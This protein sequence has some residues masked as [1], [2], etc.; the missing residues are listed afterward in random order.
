MDNVTVIRIVAALLLAGAIIPL[1]FLPGIIG[2][3]KRSNFAIFVLN[4]LLGWTVVG[5]IAALIWAVRA[6]TLVSQPPMSVRAVLPQYCSGCRSYS[7]PGV[8]ICRNCGRLL[9]SY[10][11]ENS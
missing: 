11:M 9:R 5:W 6:D 2:R 1:Y 4:L 8:G 7:M 10:R 3:K